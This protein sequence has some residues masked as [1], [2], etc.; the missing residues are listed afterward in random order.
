MYDPSVLCTLS[1]PSA[2]FPCVPC[3]TLLQVRGWK[4]ALR[5]LRAALSS[6]KAN[7]WIFYIMDLRKGI[8]SYDINKIK[9]L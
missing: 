5:A 1:S 7:K 3:H 6:S 4:A 2:H 9:C 8:E